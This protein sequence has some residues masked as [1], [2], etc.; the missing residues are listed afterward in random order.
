MSVETDVAKTSKV[1]VN[2]I[3]GDSIITKSSNEKYRENWDTI[4]GKKNREDLTDKKEES[5]L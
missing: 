5:K 2:D 1:A 4:F 3:T